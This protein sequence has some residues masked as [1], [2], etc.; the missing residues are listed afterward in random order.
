MTTLAK[1]FARKQQLN[2]RLE[3]NPGV[4]E[5]EEIERQ[6]AEIEAALNLLDQ[7]APGSSRREQR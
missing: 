6:L 7:A 2:D 5:R 3:E 1:L 4:H